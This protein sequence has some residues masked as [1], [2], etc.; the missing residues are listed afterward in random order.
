MISNPIDPGHV[1]IFNTLVLYFMT[2][3]FQVLCIIPEK[4]GPGS[5]SLVWIVKLM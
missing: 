4:I 3:S 1:T 2:F 5:V